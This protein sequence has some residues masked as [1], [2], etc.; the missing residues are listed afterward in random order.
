MTKCIACGHLII[1]NL[2]VAGSSR[3]MAIDVSALIQPYKGG[4]SKRAI[5]SAASWAPDLTARNGKPQVA[6]RKF[7]AR[8]LYRRPVSP[9]DL[10]M[11]QGRARRRGQ[12]VS[13]ASKVPPDPRV[14]STCSTS[15]S[16]HSEANP[17]VASRVDHWSQPG[18]RCRDRT[19]PCPRRISGGGQ[20]PV[21]RHGG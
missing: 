19:G 10:E 8:H 17:D 4:D 12:G 20:L 16:R 2:V 15:S 9:Y 3:W 13:L 14:L 11:L 1:T 7:R 5:M 18:D 21:E 6:G